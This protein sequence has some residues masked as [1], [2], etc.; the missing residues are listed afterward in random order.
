MCKLR[1]NKTRRGLSTGQAQKR[2]RE[3]Q[4]MSPVSHGE[5]TVGKKRSTKGVEGKERRKIKGERIVATK[6]IQG[7]V[8][9][10]SEKIS[11]A[12]K[13]KGHKVSD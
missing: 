3:K 7:K 12:E 8:Q 10:L 4:R 2:W 13:G 11:E 6:N 9:R 1:G 5:A